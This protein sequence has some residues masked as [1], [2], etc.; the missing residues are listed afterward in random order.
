M[1]E[2][3]YQPGAIGVYVVGFAI[4]LTNPSGADQPLVIA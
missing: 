3:I 1:S 4:P 2:Q